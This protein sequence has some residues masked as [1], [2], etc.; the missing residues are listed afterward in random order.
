MIIK[1]FS[2][3]DDLNAEIGK[4]VVGKFYQIQVRADYAS[5]PATFE[6]RISDR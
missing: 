6:L 4:F 3:M 1:T 2:S 5:N